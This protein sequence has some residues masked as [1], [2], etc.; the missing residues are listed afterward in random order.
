MRLFLVILTSVVVVLM[1]WSFARNA[2]ALKRDV[3][4]RFDRFRRRLETDATKAIEPL[5][6]DK[7]GQNGSKST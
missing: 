1:I 3:D 5:L 4:Q 7:S 6:R 2:I